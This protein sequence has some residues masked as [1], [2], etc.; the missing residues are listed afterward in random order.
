M[1]T[2]ASQAL[3]IRPTNLYSNG[4]IIDFPEEGESLL[5]RDIID[6]PDSPNDAYYTVIGN[7][8]LDLIAYE[9]YKDRI[10]RAA[11]LW[12]VLAD[13]NGIFNPFDLSGYIGQELRIP[14]FESII[15]YL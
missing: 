6:F 10:D 2:V 13:S 1:A 3:N 4:Y 5:L 11:E 15:P 8:R 14:A 12:W 7:E 9:S